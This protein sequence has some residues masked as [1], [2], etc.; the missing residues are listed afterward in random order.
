MNVCF[1][2]GL[3]VS[4]S[5]LLSVF[6]LTVF[7]SYLALTSPV[8]YVCRIMCIYLPARL[9]FYCLLCFYLSVSS[10][11]C[12]FV[13]LSMYLHLSL[14]IHFYPGGCL[15]PCL[16]VKAAGRTTLALLFIYVL[17]LP[18]CFSLSVSLLICPCVCLSVYLPLPVCLS[19]HQ[20]AAGLTNFA[21]LCIYYVPCLHVCLTFSAS[22]FIC[23][24]FCFSLYLF[25]RAL[26]AKALGS[27][28]LTFLSVFIYFVSAM[29]L[30]F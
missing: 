26:S 16:S 24:F 5:F 12:L 29:C 25:V 21:L 22:V 10:F 3:L 9:S 14:Y 18:V 1:C 11:L 23:P 20:G 13:H 4:L 17:C 8:C 6:Y 19:V 7:L 15:S 2:G 28:T 30:H 27:I